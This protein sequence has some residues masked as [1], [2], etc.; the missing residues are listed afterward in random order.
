MLIP[1]NIGEIV[2]V[3][4]IMCSDVGVFCLRWETGNDQV[5]YVACT[6]GLT[7]VR[8]VLVSKQTLRTF[9]SCLSDRASS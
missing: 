1:G 8:I 3:K 5:A 6:Y 2:A 7:C 4:F 9:I